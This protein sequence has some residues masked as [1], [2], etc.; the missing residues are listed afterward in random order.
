MRKPPFSSAFC[1]TCVSVGESSTIRISAIALPLTYFPILVVAGLLGSPAASQTL[2][3]TAVVDYHQHLFSPAITNGGTR[4]LAATGGVDCLADRALGVERVL[5]GT[6][7]AGGPNP[8]PQQGWAAFRE[9]P[10][11]EAELRTI[12]GN[13]APYM[14]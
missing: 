13:V 8:T 10:L 7:G 14:K 5:Y 2:T 12:A 4:R 6:D 1:I 3:P 11:T 9:L